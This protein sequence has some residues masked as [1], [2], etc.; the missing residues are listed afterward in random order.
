MYF[1][2][3]AVSTNEIEYVTFFQHKKL[4]QRES[5]QSQQLRGTVLEK[6]QAEQVH[7]E[8]GQSPRSTAGPTEILTFLAARSASGGVFLRL[9]AGSMCAQVGVG[10][11]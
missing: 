11:R 10:S 8:A 3:H 5:K 9:A 7:S 2:E 1:L 4:K 6:A